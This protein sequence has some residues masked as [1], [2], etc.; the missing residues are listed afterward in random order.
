MRKRETGGREDKEKEMRQDKSIRG[1]L[2]ETRKDVNK[3][4]EGKG[5]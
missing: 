4:N 2:Q 5:K 1:G 3:G